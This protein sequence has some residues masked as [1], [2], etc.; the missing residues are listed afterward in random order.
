MSSKQESDVAY[1][2]VYGWHHLVKATDVTA[3]QAES[4]GI[5]L[6]DEWLKV[7]CGLTAGKPGSAPAQRS[8]KL[9]FHDADTVTDTDTDTNVLADILARIVARM[10][11]C[12]SA[13]HRDRITSGNR[14]CRD[15]SATIIA[16]KSMSASWNASLTSTGNA[17]PLPLPFAYAARRG[18]RVHSLYVQAAATCSRR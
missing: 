7:T 11:A 1:A 10:S 6:P 4:N 3:G 17:L 5:Q 14:A 8:V 15:V 2:T 9:G 13:C 12:H 16:K 18:G